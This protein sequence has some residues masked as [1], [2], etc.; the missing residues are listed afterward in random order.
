MAK[1][2]TTKVSAQD[3]NKCSVYLDTVAT[4]SGHSE[5]N[6]EYDDT[7][8]TL[9][10]ELENEIKQESLKGKALE[11]GMTSF[12]DWAF[13][14]EN[15]LRYVPFEFVSK[16][17]RL[18]DCD[19]KVMS[20][21]KE[22]EAYGMPPAFHTNSIRTS[23]HT[24][25]N[26]TTRSLYDTI[27][28]ATVYYMFEPYLQDFCG[29]HRQNN[30]F[31]LRLQD[32]R[33]VTVQLASV[34]TGASAFNS[35]LL[36]NSEFR[37]GSVNFHSIYKFGT[38]EF[39]MMRASSEPEELILW[40]RILAS[41][42]AFA[43]YCGSFDKLRQ[44]VAVTDM[45]SLINMVLG[46]KTVNMLDQYLTS[47]NTKEDAVRFGYCNTLPI[48]VEGCG[49]NKEELLAAREKIKIQMEAFKKSVMDHYSNTATAG[50]GLFYTA[51]QAPSTEQPTPPK[52]NL[53]EIGYKSWT[54]GPF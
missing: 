43:L 16:P 19:A 54:G 44:I 42:R 15:S 14:N 24:H 45:S 22:M 1:K 41:I 51:T 3:T 5:K 34:L 25:F 48:I 26:Q 8:P 53:K 28:F 37:Y 23:F 18:S 2:P 49:Y 27:L 13:H 7:N 39:R 4:L 12:K 11:Y 40:Y 46:L 32:T 30:L 31:C 33:S 29:K 20:L 50:T 47:F 9:G 21:F 35:S 52:K 10:L 17:T 6:K 38:I 36:S